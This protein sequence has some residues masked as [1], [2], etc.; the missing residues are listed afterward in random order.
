MITKDGHCRKNYRTID[1]TTKLYCLIKT[2]F[3]DNLT[4]EQ[5]SKNN[6]TEASR[7]HACVAK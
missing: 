1:A 6:K 3:H 4:S 5:L 7:Y 2:F